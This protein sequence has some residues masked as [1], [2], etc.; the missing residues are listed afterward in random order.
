MV[1]KK[2]AGDGKKIADVTEVAQRPLQQSMLESEVLEKKKKIGHMFKCGILIMS[3]S[4]FY[5]IVV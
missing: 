2:G 1:E 3:Y 5:E 4:K